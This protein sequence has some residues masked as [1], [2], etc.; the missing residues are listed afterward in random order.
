MRPSS[1]LCRAQEAR[2]HALAAGSTLINVKTVANL[3]AAAWAKEA[4]LAE[5]RERRLLHR[6]ENGLDNGLPLELE[7]DDDPSF[8]ENPDRGFADAEMGWR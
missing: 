7:S 2:Q 4:L 5:G 1:I 6:Q 8:S 3:A